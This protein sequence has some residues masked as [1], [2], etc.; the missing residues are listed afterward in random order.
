MKT[1]GL[2]NMTEG[3]PWKLILRFS[4]PLLL[5]NIL[6][7]LYNVVDSIVV[8]QFVGTTALAAVGTT[9]PVIFLLNSLFIGIGI[10]ATIIVSQYYGAGNRDYV[11]KTVD[12]IYIAMFAIAVPLTLV[13]IFLARPL[14]VL[15]NTPPD[16]LDQATTYMQIIF[17][18]TIAT[19]GYNI[20]SGILQGLGDSVSP[21]LYLGLA[22]A[23][24]IVLD[25][26]FVIVFHWDVAG[27]AWATI[28]A[29]LFAFLFGIWHINHHQNYIRI[30]WRGLQPDRQILVDS[31]RLGLPSGL[32]NMSF[33]LGTMVLQ[34]L[35]NSYQSFFM[36]GYNGAGKID[37]IAFMPLM[38][39]ASAITTYVGQNIGAGKIDRVKKGLH[40]T[41][42][43]SSIVSIVICPL[44]LIFS[45]TLMRMFTNDPL[46][47]QSGMAY[48]FRVVPFYLLLSALFIIN[49]AL[50]G[51]G[52]AV[53][54]LVSAMISLWLARVPLAYLLAE[55]GRDN[56]FFS[57][58]LAWLVGL[59]VVVPY[60]LSG[61][62]KNKS[63]IRVPKDLTEGD[64]NALL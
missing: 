55:T 48:L 1:D 24:N 12:T 22:T 34:R 45:D 53:V 57:F 39:F 36:A 46:V 37:A 38:T 47:I 26:V 50:R 40:A 42:A 51:A 56:L 30:S 62:W 31:V 52:Q 27:V 16:V 33:S 17:I 54:P 32:Q 6:Q 49:G 25:L 35:I 44:I 21:L 63:M 8:G 60:Y 20:N 4:L 61:R 43:I 19:F 9:F 15:M 10:G 5:G 18:G 13:G 3:E 64:K 14:L 2:M 28:L 7:Q 29:Q 59:A 41:L 11:K 58:P 23:I